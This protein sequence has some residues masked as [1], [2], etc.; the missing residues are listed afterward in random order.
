MSLSD[1]ALEG[2]AHRGGDRYILG[3]RRKW[4]VK[5]DVIRLVATGSSNDSQ[6]AA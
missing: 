3:L 6:A 2:I 4:S 1:L 5:P